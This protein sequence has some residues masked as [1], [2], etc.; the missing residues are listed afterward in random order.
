MLKVENVIFF[1][2]CPAMRLSKFFLLLFV[3]NLLRSRGWGVHPLP[4][5]WGVVRTPPPTTLP[6]HFCTWNL[7]CFREFFFAINGASYSQGAYFWGV[8]EVCFVLLGEGHVLF[9]WVRF[10]W[11]V[12]HVCSH[13]ANWSVS[14][15]SNIRSLLV[16]DLFL[17]LTRIQQNKS[18]QQGFCIRI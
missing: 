8:F 14:L 6:Q 1:A 9:F 16:C 2:H 15:I 5:S 18:V 12:V 7:Q 17:V 13:H 3:W 11:R 10:N 4:T